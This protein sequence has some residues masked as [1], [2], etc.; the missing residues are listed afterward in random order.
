MPVERADE[1][2][3]RLLSDVD[4]LDNLDLSELIFT[5]ERRE[6]LHFLRGASEE[7]ALF[8]VSTGGSTAQVN[9]CYLLLNQKDDKPNQ[10]EQD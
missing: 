6:N 4:Y 7:N 3:D 2:G 10:A 8:V 5:Q 1:L 9:N